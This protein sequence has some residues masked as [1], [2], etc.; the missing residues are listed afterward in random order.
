VADFAIVAVA[1]SGN[2]AASVG[3]HNSG[4]G[5]VHAIVD[6]FGYFV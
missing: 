1:S 2:F 5:K 3:L 4:S 6:I